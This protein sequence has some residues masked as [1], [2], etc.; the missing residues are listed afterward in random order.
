MSSNM[1][2]TKGEYLLYLYGSAFAAIVYLY[3]N[4]RP[5]KFF[6]SKRRLCKYKRSKAL[7]KLSWDAFE[8]LCADYFEASGW[9]VEMREKNGADGGI[10]LR[11]YKRN[12]FYLVQCKRYKDA[13]VGVKTVREMYG[14]VHESS[15]DGAIIVTSSRFSKD[16][17]TFA[18]DKPIE[19]ISGET[20]SGRIDAL[21]R[22]L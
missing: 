16:A 1:I 6:P 12:K 11:L 4:I 5:R 20:F 3:V 10:D 2:A 13:V 17:V 21:C 19:L 7:K 15:A 22:R 9:R 14:L 18:S 8:V